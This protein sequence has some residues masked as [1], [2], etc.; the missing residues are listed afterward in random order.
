M[1]YVQRPRAYVIDL[2]LYKYC[3]WYNNNNNHS[4]HA[5][6]SSPP[7]VA[8]HLSIK[9]ELV[10]FQKLQERSTNSSLLV[11]RRPA[12]A[13]VRDH[14]PDALLRLSQA[15]LDVEL[16]LPV[17]VPVDSFVVLGKRQKLELEKSMQCLIPTPVPCQVLDWLGWVT[18]MRKTITDKLRKTKVCNAPSSFSFVHSIVLLKAG[19]FPLYLKKNSHCYAVTCGYRV[20]V[21]AFQY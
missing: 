11:D 4:R 5:W 15:V 19:R 18:T 3:T 17:L 6:S 10:Q 13:V 9:W 7:A 2:A 8:S 16:R 20:L 1:F 12:V 14:V 21:V